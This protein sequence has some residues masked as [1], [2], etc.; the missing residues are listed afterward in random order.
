MFPADAKLE[1]VERY[2]RALI[3]AQADIDA[4]PEKYKHHFLNEV[5]D[6]FMDMVDVRRFGVGERVVPQP[7]TESMF[8]QTQKWMHERDL[9]DV[10]AQT[11]VAYHD[12]VHR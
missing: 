6:R 4:N 1:D 3:R 7:Y 2:I 10:S 11:G 12:A 8:E 9:F 5:P